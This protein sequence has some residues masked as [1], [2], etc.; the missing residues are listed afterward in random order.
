[1]TR[2]VYLLVP[3]SIV[4]INYTFIKTFYR[5]HH[6]NN[7]KILRKDLCY[8]NNL[9]KENKY[10]QRTNNI[11]PLTNCSCMTENPDICVYN[12]DLIDIR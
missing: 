11:K 4:V 5:R 9:K 6:M 10:A 7:N 3:L 12:R 2:L 1:M 8:Q